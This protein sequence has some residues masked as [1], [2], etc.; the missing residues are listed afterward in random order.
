MKMTVL[1]RKLSLWLVAML[2]L[3]CQYALANPGSHSLS[4]Q[5]IKATKL[6]D[7]PIPIL[8]GGYSD[9]MQL[10]LGISCL[11]VTPDQISFDGGSRSII[12]LGE[13]Y[14]FHDIQKKLNVDITADGSVDLF[15]SSASLDYA[16][17]VEETNYSES[18][19]YLEQITLPTKIFTPFGFGQAAL[20]SF[21][22]LASAAGSDQFRL[23]CGNEFIQQETLGANFFTT[24]KVNFNSSYDKSNFDTTVR[25][26]IGDFFDASSS[27]Q[28][29]VQ[30]NHIQGALEIVAYQE[31]GDPSQLAQ[32]FAKGGK[33]G[34]SY[35]VTQCSLDNLQA[36]QGT[37]DGIIAY[38]QNM[39]P[40]QIDFQN[41]Q[42]VGNANP[43]GYAYMDYNNLGLPVGS[44]K[45][46]PEIMAARFYLG[47]LYKDTSRNANIIDHIL[48]S[49][50]AATILK[51]YKD[52]LQALDQA[53]HDNLALLD[54]ENYGAIGCY[55]YP[56]QC[57]SIRQQIDSELKQI[58]TATLSMFTTGYIDR[59]ADGPYLIMPIGGDQYDAFNNGGLHFTAQQTMQLSPD[60]T[61][62]HVDGT[63][64]GGQHFWGDFNKVGSDTYTGQL[65]YDNGRVDDHQIDVV[66]NPA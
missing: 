53:L 62:L 6:G 26:S 35:C 20:N 25:G 48:H 49:Q 63:D 18:F 58:D 51:D 19:Y 5:K 3:S 16:N 66:E 42:I 45:T 11:T 64:I 52:K 61:V 40:T 7:F 4:Q 34:D 10:P 38:S 22:L 30:Q 54:N 17:Y 9:D 39:L 1:V 47:G 60:A 46:T 57:V 2:C 50:V 8:S 36:C 37:I 43:I 13:A 65:H 27:I 33:C 24:F 15:S 32:I 59:S 28:T 44:T 23:S 14:N 12:E 56:T 31:G 21:G 55:L 29:A 41:G